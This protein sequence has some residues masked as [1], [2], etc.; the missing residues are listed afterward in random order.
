VARIEAEVLGH[1]TTQATILR[2]MNLLPIAVEV[3][4]TEG[5]AQEV[6]EIEVAGPCTTAH[7]FPQHFLQNPPQTSAQEDRLEAASVLA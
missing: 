3:V 1:A 2:T 4:G 5:G 7:L 6:G